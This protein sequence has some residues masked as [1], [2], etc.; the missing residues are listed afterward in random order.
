V[1]SADKVAVERM[2][3]ISQHLRLYLGGLISTY[4]DFAILIYPAME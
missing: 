3:K 4:A 2:D 1:D